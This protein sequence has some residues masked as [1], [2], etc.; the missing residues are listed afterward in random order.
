MEDMPLRS[1]PGSFRPI[2][3]LM[4]VVFVTFPFLALAMPVLPL[5]VHAGLGLG[6]FVVGLVA[7]AFPTAAARSA[8]SSLGR[9]RKPVTNQP[10]VTVSRLT[11]RHRRVCKQRLH[12]RVRTL[13]STMASLCSWSRAAYTSVTLPFRTHSR[14]S[15]KASALCDSSTS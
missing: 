11:I 2:L 3:P 7:G 14:S 13:R 4:A 12:C 9:W 10:A 6:T 5:H 8:P 15:F 1:A